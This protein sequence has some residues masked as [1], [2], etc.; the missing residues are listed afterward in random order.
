MCTFTLA[1]SLDEN[2]APDELGYSPVALALQ[3]VYF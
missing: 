2:A 1:S 3:Q